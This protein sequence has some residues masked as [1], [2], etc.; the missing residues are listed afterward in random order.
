MEKLSEAITVTTVGDTGA[1]SILSVVKEAKRALR[2]LVE[3]NYSKRLDEP[4]KTGRRIVVTSTD[5]SVLN[6]LSIAKQSFS[7]E[8]R[9]I[10]CGRDPSP[11]F[12][13][14]LI[15]SC[16][17][18]KPGRI[19]FL[20]KDISGAD[21]DIERMLRLMALPDA[22]QRI[23]HATMPSDILYLVNARLDHVQLPLTKLQSYRAGTDEKQWSNLELDLA[24][25]SYVYWPD[26]D[27]H[28]GWPELKRID[29]P[30]YKRPIPE[31]LL[32]DMKNLGMAFRDMRKER[33]L[34]RRALTEKVR[35]GNLSEKTLSRVEHGQQFPSAKTIG[36][37]A[38]A[39]DMSY[40]E[41]VNALASRSG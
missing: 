11:E 13:V 36:K 17:V 19:T 14:R 6:R 23:F 24:G 34:S 37:I 21:E 16:R 31:D 26:L 20:D 30:D 41:L 15:S 1:S 33:G 12:V 5:E 27:L 39:F 38:G 2:K 4:R 8:D 10:V 28:L 35:D 3:L 18:Q 25:G 22:D 7:A 32:A 29:D 40:A 9:F